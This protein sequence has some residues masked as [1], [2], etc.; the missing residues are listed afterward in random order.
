MFI[1]KNVKP[2]SITSDEANKM[3]FY[4]TDY[5]GSLPP[6]INTYICE[7]D[8]TMLIHLTDTPNEIFENEDIRTGFVQEEYEN[9]DKNIIA[10]FY[11]IPV[12][13]NADRMKEEIHKIR[14]FGFVDITNII[15][16]ENSLIFMKSTPEEHQRFI[17]SQFL[18]SFKVYQEIEGKEKSIRLESMLPFN[19]MYF[20]RGINIETSM[21]SYVKTTELKFPEFA[22]EILQPLLKESTTETTETVE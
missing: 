15:G 6:S 16:Y 9:S 10:F 5:I 22:K 20:P 8:S 19:K 2:Q 4:M 13:M 12:D 11:R 7:V 1:L 21:P 17:I 3:P 14:E 18:Y